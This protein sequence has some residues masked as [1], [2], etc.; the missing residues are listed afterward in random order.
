MSNLP[1]DRSLWDNEDIVPKTKHGYYQALKDSANAKPSFVQAHSQIFRI[2][3]DEF[4]PRVQRMF[5]GDI[6]VREGLD[7]Y[8]EEI[9]KLLERVEA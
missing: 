9:N 4:G 7:E 8:V 5:R 2:F 6:S 1:A 3:Y